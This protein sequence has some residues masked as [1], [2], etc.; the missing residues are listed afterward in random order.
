MSRH[1]TKKSRSVSLYFWPSNSFTSESAIPASADLIRKSYA[2]IK[3]GSMDPVLFVPDS[4]PK[5][6]TISSLRP[7]TKR[8]LREAYK[9]L[10]NA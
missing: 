1:K 6:P 5:V 3:D 10:K 9:D 2:S 8:E 7:A 4:D